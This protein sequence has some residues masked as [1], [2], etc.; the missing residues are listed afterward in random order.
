VQSTHYQGVDLDEQRGVHVWRR[1]QFESAHR[2][3]RVPPGHKCGRMHG[4]GFAVL[5]HAQSTDASLDAQ[6]LDLAWAPLQQQLQH[7]CLNDIAGLENPT[8]ELIAGWIWARLQPRLSGLCWVTVYETATC[9]AHFDGSQYRIW[10]DLGLDSAVRLHHAP[11][12]DRRGRTHGH[13]YRL[14]LHLAAP[15]DT[16]LGWTIDFGDVKEIFNP[17]YAQLDHHPLHEL[18]GVAEAG[19]VGIARWAREQAA[20]ALP[21]IERIDLYESPGCGV[22]YSWGSQHPALPD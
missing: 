10:K 9:G 19:A 3:P 11:A 18:P 16:L 1:Y 4:H 7:A 2:L 13:S 21:Q 12:G 22:I 15:L 20:A 14:R 5:L 17:V 6:A 8:S